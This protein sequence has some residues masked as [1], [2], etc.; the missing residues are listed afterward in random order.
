MAYRCNLKSWVI[1]ESVPQDNRRGT[2]ASSQVSSYVPQILN[3]NTPEDLDGQ[4]PDP[5]PAGLSR[6]SANRPAGRELRN[7]AACYAEV[8]GEAPS[9]PVEEVVGYCG[10]DPEGGVPGDMDSVSVSEEDDG[11]EEITKSGCGFGCL[12]RRDGAIWLV[13]EVFGH[14]C[15]LVR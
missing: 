1:T 4:Y 7:H 8:F 12:A 14:A 11:E 5:V 6:R 15:I 13:D 9:G 3:R 10:E 2:S